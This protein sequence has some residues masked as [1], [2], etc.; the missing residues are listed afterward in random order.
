MTPRS[1]TSLTAVQDYIDALLCEPVADG[2]ESL[3]AAMALGPEPE[4][5][6][7]LAS[8][9]PVAPMPGQ[10]AN[11]R[12]AAAKRTD[13][14]ADTDSD[15]ETNPFLAQLVQK[16]QAGA[17]RSD[18]HDD[19]ALRPLWAADR[20]SCQGFN[21][22]G[23][24]L[25]IPAEYIA[26]MQA[27][28]LVPAA[29]N[30]PGPASAAAETVPGS[31][32]T[33][34]YL[35]QLRLHEDGSPGALVDVLDTARLVMPERYDASMTEAYRYVLTLRDCDWCIAVD[36]IA[37]ELSFD[38]GRVRWRSAHT[39]REWLAGTVVDK[40]CALVDIDALNR[41]RLADRVMCDSED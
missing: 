27:L 22:G 10:P 13:Q 33:M 21:V 40:M 16:Q 15:L 18:S 6:E 36:S 24:K 26:G 3:A 8:T 39:R 35:G 37:G 19:S 25:A 34:H 23:L 28:E 31:G 5:V 9:D 38:A 2:S 29:S 4:I 32:L 17:S 30:D 41:H 1:D 12:A 7:P 14:S 20:F 11:T